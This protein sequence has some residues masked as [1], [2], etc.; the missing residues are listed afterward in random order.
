MGEVDWE[1]VG[2]VLLERERRPVLVLDVQGRIVRVNRALLHFIEDG[3]RTHHVDFVNE[4]VAATSRQTFVEAWR[5]ALDGGRPRAAI[6]IRPS[7]FQLEPIFEF[8]PLA[9]SDG[10]VRSVMM[11]IV[12]VVATVPALPLTPA[13]GVVYEVAIDRQ[14]RP[15][16][17]LRALSAD[18]RRKLD[19]TVD[20]FKA[21]HDRDEPCSG[22]PLPLL[23][24]AGC[25]TTVRLASSLPFQAELLSARRLGDESVV[26][27]AVSLD[28]P[29]YSGIVQAR[30]EALSRHARLS[31]RER[32][33][34]ALLLLGRNLDDVAVAEGITARTAKFHQ[35]NVLRKLG[36]DSRQDLFRLLS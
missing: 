35:R 3:V 21:L 32:N 17:L 33:V 15:R 26:L 28:E 30:V 24:T 22:C 29:V 1:F 34:L 6:S 8:V 14:G 20:C 2:A 12:D 4:W 5:R 25:V 19:T 16:R 13:V 18:R 9:G 27:N 10:L 31:G 36:A 11:V 7:A 23:P